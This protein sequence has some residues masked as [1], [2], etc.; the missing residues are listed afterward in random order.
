MDRNSPNQILKRNIIF[1]H[2]Q[3]VIWQTMN[4]ENWLELHYNAFLVV[5]HLQRAIFIIIIIIIIIIIFFFY[6]RANIALIQ[7]DWCN[8]S[9][10]TLG[11]HFH[12]D[13]TL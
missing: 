2:V 10:Q 3:S 1:H 9:S 6:K 4:Y 11:M 5:C 8:I 13:F 7:L 12:S